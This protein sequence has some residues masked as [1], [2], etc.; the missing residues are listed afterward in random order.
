MSELAPASAHAFAE[1]LR[2]LAAQRRRVRLAGLSTRA[3]LRLAAPE[4]TVV[5]STRALRAIERLEPD[6]LTCSVEPGLPCR[7]L[8]AAL[9]A[10]GLELDCLS[11][12]DEGT[13]GGLYASDPLGAPVAGGSSPRSTL[14]GLDGVLANGTRFRS[15]ARVVKSVAGFDVHR[16][17]VG[18][19]GR[20]YAAT[21][22]HLKLRPAPRARIAFATKS[23]ELDATLATFAS[24]RRLPSGLSRLALVREDRGF[25]VTG[26]LQGRPR[27]IA[28]LASAHGF[29]ENER[30]ARDHLSAP[31]DGMELLVGCIRPSRLPQLLT[32]LPPNAPFLAHAGGTFEAVLTTVEADRLL[33]HLPGLQAHGV[34]ALG[35]R[36]RTGTGTPLDPGAARLE[37][38]L[39]LALDPDDV[40][41]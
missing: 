36:S 25:C 22:L 8:A 23:A 11:P 28:S 18:S 41:A 15:G 14:L 4:G 7:E 17:L 20:L 29:V 32:Q 19:R 2:D 30:V 5:V 37:R 24:L 1:C 38:D 9:Q 10:K 31:T 26:V 34:V 13:I 35:S 27:H 40:L 16:L 21:L 6:D 39:R 33:A 12:D 3:R